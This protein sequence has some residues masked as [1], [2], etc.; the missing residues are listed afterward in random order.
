MKTDTIRIAGAGLS[1]LSA[2]I[3]LAQRGH[4]VEVFEKNAESGQTR[5]ADWDAIENWTTEED[6]LACLAQWGIQPTYEYRAPSSFEVYDPKGDC[7]QV[8][9]QRPFFYLLKRGVE[10]GSIEQALKAQAL[11][12]GVTIHYSRASVKDEV[13][14]WAAGARSAGFFLGT[15]ITFR[16]SHPDLVAGLVDTLAAPKAYAYLVIV[17]GF[18]TLSVVLTQ[19]FKQ[20]RTYLDHCIQRFRARKSFD[21]RD[22][23]RTSGFGGL[24]SAFWQ[25]ASLRITV[26]EAAGLQD[27]LW[28]FG[29]RHAMHS[30]Y[31]AARA[32]HEGLDYSRLIGHEIQ[33]LVRASLINR[34]FY[35]R[36]GNRAYTAL[37]RHFAASRDLSSSIRPWYRGL[38]LHKIMWPLAER[39]YCPKGA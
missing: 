20:A 6:F 22:I 37:I 10:H 30:G 38:P 27:F 1:G 3:C 25:P 31:L 36:V 19:D 14:I 21:M 4:R 2:A 12:Y 9:L 7:Y 13:D 33:P 34:M 16:T 15:G 5:H 26:G 23:K 11:E 35:D 39:R 28:G 18:A 17:D 29:I 24:V 8:H 32:L